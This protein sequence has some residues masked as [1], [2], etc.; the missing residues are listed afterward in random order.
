MI[1]AIS[2]LSMKRHSAIFTFPSLAKLAVS[3]RAWTQLSILRNATP[4]DVIS[5][6]DYAYDAAGRRI[7]I[8]RSGTAMSESR[9]DAYGYNVRNELTSAT[10]LGGP[11]SVP[12]SHEYA[13]QY[14]D[15]GNRITST[16]LTTNRTYTANSLN[17]Y[18]LVGRAVPGAP[19][20]EVEE[21]V[22][23]FD[24]DGNQTLI[25]TSTGIW[26]VQYNGEN[27][28]VLWT[29]GTQSA[30]TN[31]VMSF[32]RMGRRVEYL[33]T[34]GGAQSSATETNACHRFL[35][36]NYLCIQRLDAANGNAVDLAFVWDVTEPVATR[37]LVFLS[38]SVL[39]YYTHD[40]NKNVTQLVSSAGDVVGQYEYSPFGDV[41][42]SQYATSTSQI[43]PH[44][45][46]PFRFSSE[47]GEG[48]VAL[49]S[50]N[51]RHYM[52][53][54]GRWIS[55]D[56]AEELGSANLYGFLLGNPISEFDVLGLF[57]PYAS[58]QCEKVGGRFRN[59][60]CCC[61]DVEFKT[62]YKCCRAG[63]ILSDAKE[64]S[65]VSY[66][67]YRARWYYPLA[68]PILRPF[69]PTQFMVTH[70]WFKVDGKRFGAYPNRYFKDGL[71]IRD[72]ALM[73]GHKYGD[74]E[75]KSPWTTG[76]PVG[77]SPCDYD[78]GKFKRCVLDSRERKDFKWTLRNNCRDFVIDTVSKCK[79]GAKV[80]R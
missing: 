13:Y 74:A 71:S 75:E 39:S 40:G 48:S 18:T 46:N 79:E 14:D 20:G 61:G 45:C 2:C 32:D 69:S 9:T 38:G 21:F 54:G 68:Q 34:A 63:K 30:A 26:Q 22:P 29:G 43:N 10:K 28:P 37:P 24:D 58:V 8:A 44:V 33:E 47:H 1:Y 50:Y 31:I 11:A 57:I 41:V 42:V 7:E 5:Q 65:G 72:E 3:L 17:Q 35:Y 6:Y 66:F 49:V 60:K 64:D 12:A 52:S 27:R 15:I 23:Q 53:I 70:C 56:L 78:L 16:D 51:Y 19:Q 55:R 59:N 80:K 36:D 62:K 25:Q 4:T 77:L 73:E 67:C 76:G